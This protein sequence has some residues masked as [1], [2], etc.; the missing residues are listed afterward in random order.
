MKNRDMAC[1]ATRSEPSHC[2]VVLVDAKASHR[3][4]WAL[5]HESSTVDLSIEGRIH[6]VRSSAGPTCRLANL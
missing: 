1:S 2:R 6:Y 4:S 3:A 5:A